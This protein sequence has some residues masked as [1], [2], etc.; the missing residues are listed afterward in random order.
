MP[1]NNGESVADQDSNEDVGSSLLPAKP[2]LVPD[3][4]GYAGFPRLDRG[5]VFKGQCP[6][7]KTS[8]LLN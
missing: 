4:V 3:H 1:R 7:G 6:P 2:C 5:D 8:F